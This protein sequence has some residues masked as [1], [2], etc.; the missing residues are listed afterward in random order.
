MWAL[1][2]QAKPLDNKKMQ[3]TKRGVDGA[4][5]LIF[6]FDRRRGDE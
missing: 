3:R 2:P 6:V 1:T 5:P 4:S